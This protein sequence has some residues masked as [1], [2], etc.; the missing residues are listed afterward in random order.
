MKDPYATLG[1]SK[2]AS[3]EEIKKAYRKLAKKLHPDVNPGDK[4]SEEKFKDVSSA[5]DVV[6]DPK[7]RALFDEFG[8]AATR[9]GFDEAK[10]REYQKQQADFGRRGGFAGGELRPQRSGLHV[11]RH[12]LAAAGWP[13]A[14]NTRR[15]G[16][17]RRRRDRD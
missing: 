15:A 13:D 7:K 1:V 16:A 10:A 12:L 5:F 14:A 2:S 17:G 9:S 3:A 8:E 4:K 6:G 11:R